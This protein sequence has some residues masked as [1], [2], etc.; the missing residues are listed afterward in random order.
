[1]ILGTECVSALSGN[2]FQHHQQY[3]GPNPD[4]GRILGQ[5]RLHRIGF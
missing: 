2:F 3:W 5:N 1:M 4:F